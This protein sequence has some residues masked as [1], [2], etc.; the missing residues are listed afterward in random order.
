MTLERRIWLNRR[1]IKVALIPIV[2]LLSLCASADVKVEGWRD[3][4]YDYIISNINDYPDYIFL[5]SSN[6]WGWKYASLINS[7]GPFG[8]GYKLDDFIIH[9]IRASDFDK[10][11]FLS[12]RDEYDPDIVNCTN[13][14]QNNSKIVSSSLILPKATSIEEI[15]SLKK[16]EV[17]LK[18][19]NITD[20]AL[21]ISKI[22]TLYYYENGTVQELLPD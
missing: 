9:A 2:L 8:K 22:K 20:Q 15:L 16:I 18:I 7:T 6:I 3:L 14:C 11:S 4:S 19:D 10:D 13:Y 21:N 12:Q 5:T 1:K 17:F